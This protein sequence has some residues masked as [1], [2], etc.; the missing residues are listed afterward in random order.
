MPVE[1]GR[2]RRECIAGQSGLIKGNPMGWLIYHP[3]KL[4][5]VFSRTT[6]SLLNLLHK[7]G[8]CRFKLRLLNLNRLDHWR[9]RLFLVITA[10]ILGQSSRKHSPIGSI[11]FN[12]EWRVGSAFPC[13]LS[14]LMIGG[15]DFAKDVGGM[16]LWVPKLT[17]F[18]FHITCYKPDDVARSRQPQRPCRP[19]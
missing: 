9:S 8:G 11:A 2:Y 14:V 13:L 5:S 18:A 17:R 4:S 7:A 6:N 3:I 15:N 16:I 10:P 12:W 19:W 1:S